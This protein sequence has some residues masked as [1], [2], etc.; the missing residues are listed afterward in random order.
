MGSNEDPVQP[1]INTL[2]KKSQIIQTNKKTNVPIDHPRTLEGKKEAEKATQLD[3]RTESYPARMPGLA[4][5][6]M[7]LLEISLPHLCALVFLFQMRK[8]Y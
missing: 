1:K 3:P 4:L 8:L 2:K 5:P 6:L 7:R